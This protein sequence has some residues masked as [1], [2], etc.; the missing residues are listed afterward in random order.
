MNSRLILL[1]LLASVSLAS[2]LPTKGGSGHRT[3]SLTSASKGERQVVS[4]IEY[5]RQHQQQVHYAEQQQR[6]LVSEQREL[7]KTRQ[8]EEPKRVEL[9]KTEQRKEEQQVLLE[10]QKRNEQTAFHQQQQQREETSQL[11]DEVISQQHEEVAPTLVSQKEESL[12]S[13]KSIHYEAKPQIREEAAPAKGVASVQRVEVAEEKKAPA[14]SSEQ[15]QLVPVKFEQQRFESSDE[16]KGA[17]GAYEQ[18][19][20]TSFEQ[21]VELSK[22]Y[23]QRRLEDHQAQFVQQQEQFTQQLEEQ[24]VA[25]VKGA[26]PIPETEPYAFDYSVEGSS[27]RESGDTKGVVR[28]QYTLQNPDGSRR[29][30]DYIAD[31]DGFR[32]TV[33][34]NE[35]GTESKAPANVNLRSSQPSAEDISLRLEGKTKEFFVPRTNIEQAPIR[36]ENWNVKGGYQEKLSDVSYQ[37]EEIRSTSGLKTSEQAAPLE[38]K[39]PLERKQTKG[40]PLVQQQIEQAEIKQQPQL[41]ERQ[42]VAVAKGVSKLETIELPQ[43]SSKEELKTVEQAPL[44]ATEQQR[45]TIKSAELRAP[46][47][48]DLYSTSRVTATAHRPLQAVSVVHAQTPRVNHVHQIN[49]VR[50]SHSHLYPQQIVAGPRR[51]VRREHTLVHQHQPVIQSPR[52]VAVG[53]EQASRQ[54]HSPRIAS[55]SN[56]V[57]EE[58]SSVGFEASRS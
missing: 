10:G 54:P 50:H 14:K 5:Q 45:E 46:K 44:L 32:A 47:S 37:Q 49:P 57:S 13:T 6:E 58:E 20:E 51:A 3:E 9:S 36:A 42:S 30:V 34:T 35:F 41:F 2:A 40:Q 33:N 12:S 48:I 1:G 25:G 56:I 15:Q 29:V 8:E 28:G 53:H 22:D 23:E 17:A 7:S 31:R 38:T 19:R 4:P 26:A 43:Q 39:A 21:Q 52:Y 24:R 27:R 55:Y 18:Q 16:L 11:K